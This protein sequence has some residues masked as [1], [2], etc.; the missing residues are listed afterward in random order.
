VLDC[1]GGTFQG[2]GVKTVVLFFEKGAP[3]RK[4]WFY[5]LDPGRNM[6]KT[7]PLNDADL[8]DFIDR[9]KTFADSP[10]SWS[11]D[12]KDIDPKTCDLSV[13]NPDGG[14]EISHRS[15]AD[16]MKEIAAL[17]KESAE[18]LKSIKALL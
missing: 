17:D 13:K 7:N 1:P 18:V 4:V 10:K 9:Q 6:G 5:Q 11:V 12:V 8:A 3:T 15:P 2:A 14:E 16:I